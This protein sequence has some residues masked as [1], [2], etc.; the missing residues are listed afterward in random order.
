M[1]WP[2]LGAAVGI[3]VGIESVHTEFNGLPNAISIRSI[4]TP[5]PVNG[6]QLLICGLQSEQQITVGRHRPQ[7]FGC[8]RLD[9]VDIR[10]QVGQGRRDLVS[11]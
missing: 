10:T 7:V 6:Y 3:G 8:N 5:I 9:S 4:P 2:Q 1:T 11:K